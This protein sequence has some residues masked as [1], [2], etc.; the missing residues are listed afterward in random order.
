MNE[1]GMNWATLI[2]SGAGIVVSLAVM[3]I[4][5]LNTWYGA[6]THEKKQAV[7]VVVGLVV[8]VAT[9]A[10]GCYN[11]LP[12]PMTC[13]KKTIWDALIAWIGFA[14]TNQTTY[15]YTG[16]LVTPKTLKKG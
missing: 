1:V 14:V 10:A 11:L 6:L 9:V 7:M 5:G 15:N 16:Y 12:G 3:L 2:S 13:D 4:P 8:A